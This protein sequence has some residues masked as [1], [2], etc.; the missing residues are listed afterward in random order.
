VEAIQ[1]KLPTKIEKL[2]QFTE[3][4]D[5]PLKMFPDFKK[6]LQNQLE[7]HQDEILDAITNAFAEEIEKFDW[8][9]TDDVQSI[10]SNFAERA[11]RREE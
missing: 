11:L 4:E 8:I 3:N 10:T 6:D 5:A 9:D 7:T 2:I 1:F